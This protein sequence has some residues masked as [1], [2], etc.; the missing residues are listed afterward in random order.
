MYLCVFHVFVCIF[1]YVYAFVYLHVFV[2]I[3]MHSNVLACNQNFDMHV[4][5]YVVRIKALKRDLA[6]LDRVSPPIT[7]IPLQPRL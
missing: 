2:F 5:M 7:I 4:C 3:C 6:S 1:V